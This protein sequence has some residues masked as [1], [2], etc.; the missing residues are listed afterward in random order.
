MVKDFASGELGAGAGAGALTGADDAAT[1]GGAEFVSQ[2]VLSTAAATA[3]RRGYLRFK[4]SCMG[5]QPIQF[6]N[7]CQIHNAGRRRST[8]PA[9]LKPM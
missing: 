9:G 4:L 1:V 5:H 7:V 2:P 8:Y 6:H 3:T